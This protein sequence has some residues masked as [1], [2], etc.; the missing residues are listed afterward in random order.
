MVRIGVSGRAGGG[1]GLEEWWA[2][3]VGGFDIVRECYPPRSFELSSFRAC[4]LGGEGKLT[5]S[6]LKHSRLTA[7]EH[8]RH[9]AGG[10]SSDHF[11]CDMLFRRGLRILR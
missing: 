1:I 9:L 11:V 3:W 10:D 4:V 8:G 6:S 2:G 5:T 7:G